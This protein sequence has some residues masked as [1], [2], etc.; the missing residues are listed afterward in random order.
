MNRPNLPE[1]L[2]RVLDKP[3]TS[4]DSLRVDKWLSYVES[5]FP[6]PQ[7]KHLLHGD[8]QRTKDLLRVL[9]PHSREAWVEGILKGISIASSQ[10]LSTIKAL[11][12]REVNNR[13]ANHG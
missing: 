12:A 13:G 9:A 10:R 11:F 3:F 8:L 2:D 1:W 4:E 5:E 7:G 6:Q